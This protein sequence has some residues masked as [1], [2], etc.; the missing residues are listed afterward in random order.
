MERFPRVGMRMIKTSMAVGL[1]FLIFVLR[2]QKGDPVLSSIAAIICM[3][4]QVENSMSVAMNRIRGTLMGAAFGLL[5]VVLVDALPSD[6]VYLGYGIIS[7]CIIPVLYV[8]VLFRQPGSS[9]LATIVF[10]SIA[11]SMGDRPPLENGIYRS[12]ET[13][14]GVLV[15]LGVNVLH[16]PRRKEKDILFISGFDGALYNEEHGITPYCTFELNELLQSGAPF[17]IATERTPASLLEDLRTLHLN[18]PVIAMDGAVL[19]DVKE[20]RYL[21]CQGLSDETSDRIKIMLRGMDLGYFVNVVWQDVL[22]IFYEQLKNEEERKLY[23]TARRSPHRN[24]V[25]GQRPEGSTVVYILLVVRDEV[26]DEVEKNL[27]KLQ[28]EDELQCLRDYAETPEGFCHLKIYHKNATKEYMMYKLLEK[29]DQKKIVV[30]GSNEND[31]S[32][33]ASADLSY[34]TAKATPAAVAVADYQLKGDSGDSVVR[35]VLHLY[36]PLRWRKLP[37]ELLQERKG[38]RK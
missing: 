13:I 9:A 3:Q 18:L 27:C 6:Y 14:I 20:K 7:L 10:L 8:T 21:A 31:L 19:Y 29:I 11:M 15:S 26:A 1:C 2:G 23:E 38:N 17:T 30:F 22:L 5:V 33:M 4:P 16:L 28:L 32:M 25:Y 12:I 24:Y 37:K 35:K 34:A 36:E